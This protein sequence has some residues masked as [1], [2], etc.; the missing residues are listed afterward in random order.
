MPKM[1]EQLCGPARP[2]SQFPKT[3]HV[4][5]RSDM[6]DLASAAFINDLASLADSM[7]C[8]EKDSK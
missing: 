2:G 4:D 7:A 5:E 3:T 6:A 1:D 8:T